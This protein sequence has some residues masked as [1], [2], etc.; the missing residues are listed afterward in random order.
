MKTRGNVFKLI[1]LMLFILSSCLQ[2]L[3]VFANGE[4]TSSEWQ[5]N[6]LNED[7]SE[8][9]FDMNLEDEHTDNGDAN[10]EML[11]EETESINFSLPRDI[12]TTN[13]TTVSVN[14]Q[15]VND[16]EQ[17]TIRLEFSDATGEI[18]AGDY[19]TMNWQNN[20]EG[21]S[22]NAFVGQKDLV[23]DGQVVGVA[24]IQD[25]QV[26]ITFNDRISDFE[27]ISGYFEFK[28]LARNHTN[29][30]Q[31]D[32][33]DIVVYSGNKS[34][35]VS[36]YKGETG[37]AT[38]TFYYKTG[39]MD[40]QHPEKVSWWLVINASEDS[41][42]RTWLQNSI[43]LTDN[44]GVGHELIEDSIHVTV[45]TS[46]GSTTYSKTDFETTYNAIIATTD[47]TLNITI[48][49]SHP[50]NNGYTVSYDTLITE[51]GKKLSKFDNTSTINY[52]ELYKEPTSV[53]GDF[54]VNNISY[55]AGIIGQKHGEVKIIKTLANTNKALSNI[56]FVIARKD[57]TPIKGQPTL[58]VVTDDNG[59][60]RA[61][62]LLHGDYI[63]T[64][65]NPEWLNPME[66]KEFTIV[67]KDTKIVEIGIENTKKQV[68]LGVKKEWRGNSIPN[69]KPTI[70]FELNRRL[71]GG[72]FE[73]VQTIELSHEETNDKYL[74]FDKV[75][76]T[77]DNGQSYEYI[78]NEKYKNQPDV[79]V[80][81]ET[82][83]QNDVVTFI[84]EYNTPTPVATVVTL[85]VHKAL[86]G[87][88]LR[89][90]EFEFV[91]S[92]KGAEQ[93]TVRNTA[94]GKVTFKP[95][96]YTAAGT[97]TYSITE[98]AGNINNVTYSTEAIEV[99]VNVVD[100]K[101]QLEATVTYP[102]DRTFNNQYVPTP[103]EFIF[104][105][106]KRLTGKPLS[107]DAY[108]FE[109]RE[110]NGTVL[111]TAKNNADGRVTFPAINYTRAGVF[112][113]TIHEVQGNEAGVTYDSTVYPVTV[114]VTDDGN[115][116][117]TI[118]ST[119]LE[120]AIFTNNY[121]PAPTSASLSATKVL[122]GKAL[123]KDQ[124]T[125]E[126][127]EGT[128]VVQTVKNSADGSIKFAP[129]T[130]NK[131]GVHTYTISE[132]SE[133]L[134][135]ITY[136]ETI[137]EVTVTVTDKGGQLE[138]T[139]AYK[140]GAA[141]VF[142]NTYTV[143]PI[144]INLS[145]TKALTGKDLVKNAYTFQVK[146]AT[147]KVVSE[148]T[149][150]SDGQV[151]FPAIE[152][153]SAGT[154][155]FTVSE[156]TG[157]EAGVTYDAKVYDVAVTVVDNGNGTLTATVT[158]ADRLS[159]NNTYV[160]GSTSA[161][162]KAMKRLSGQELKS[163]QFNFE[164][165][166]G[167]KVLETVQNA[168]DGSIH[169]APITYTKVGRYTYTISEI[170]GTLGGITYDTTQHT[171]IVE[172]TDA[173]GQLVAEVQYQDNQVPVFTNTYA[174][175]PTTVMLMANKSLTGKDLTK[176]A[177]TFQV[178][179][180]MGKVVSEVKN[181]ED[182]TIKFPAIEFAQT[183]TFQFTVSEVVGNE[184]GV[185]YD[186]TIHEVTVTV[187][188]NGDGTLT[189]TATQA[190][191]L[192]FK[193]SYA[194]HKV[195]ANL[196]AKKILEGRPLVSGEFTF[197]LKQGDKVVDTATNAIDG[198]VN[199][200]AIEYD[201]VGDY[202]YTIQ[203]VSQAQAGIA[204]DT[205]RYEVTVKVT[206]E[207][208]QLVATVQYKDGKAPVFTNK[209]TAKPTELK[210]VA[211]K[212]LEGKDL[213]KDTYTFQVKDETGKVVAEAKNEADGTI[214]FPAIP[215]DK[216]GRFTYKVSEVKGTE[217]HVTYDETVHEVTVEVVDS[218][219]GIL[220]INTTGLPN[221]T[222]VNKYTPPKKELP[223]TGEIVFNTSILGLAILLTLPSYSI[224]KQKRRN[225]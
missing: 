47:N 120:S 20:Q 24:S 133:T 179:D 144:S 78:V 221:I 95:I 186:R 148:A 76:A 108:T 43:Y 122:T 18:K 185:T 201:K 190:D 106:T 172:V 49:I 208:G 194:P 216:A 176:D 36:I 42:T 218:G 3:H 14:P 119:G 152:F 219:A 199:F 40:P 209:Y 134:G 9:F 112:K 83:Q 150:T 93:Q 163:G 15:N 70:L 182:G 170:V 127:K 7:V 206:D 115:G 65:K 61:K 19:I 81:S 173:G 167:D 67:E 211:K 196:S 104:T 156:V 32:T 38:D 63:L 157:T 223:K 25:S 105:A 135:G 174:T 30:N 82:Y 149:N 17:V 60:A 197:E 10:E 114:T 98:K 89:A 94:D 96:N 193:N 71:P 215:I 138:A 126:L 90:N 117:L 91:L 56:E 62:D 142:T 97:Y 160:P 8:N 140:E 58:S 109:L 166:E 31:A 11:E 184:R 175:Q 192:M 100:N 137:H 50:N 129:I 86:A 214:T 75:D 74:Y 213:T 212:R 72:N 23:I 55:D 102:E 4:D 164:L 207:A 41:N 203:E 1:F 27:Q 73:V 202:T 205:T 121:T 12:S 143:T 21:A 69:P 139:V 154:F 189:A 132:V 39:S 101:G 147:G 87:R 110:E 177:Y 103:K 48:P 187:V 80:K 145:A 200:K 169:F 59:I 183:G 168:T 123:A 116:T 51:E 26:T 195:S 84:N 155:N 225:A 53:Q 118:K 107:A 5:T 45:R 35:A 204:Y 46:Q 198:T 136:D 68:Q 125:F 141:P 28:A 210:L 131:V 77:D 224:F 111:G 130:Y 113:Y 151:N 79:I 52:H 92:E 37:I 16:N 34:A 128:R 217:A 22:L 33:K 124:F 13:V 57:G 191:D 153:T 178:K 158:G 64:E 162:L 161:N 180:T 159:F 88:D 222:F 66:P 29:T 188:D 6:A 99:V 165:K 85:E 146:D 44:I 171:V 2:P 54:S 181:A 220:V